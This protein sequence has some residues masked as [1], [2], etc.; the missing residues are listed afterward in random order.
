MPPSPNLNRIAPRFYSTDSYSSITEISR[1]SAFGKVIVTKVTDVGGNV[2]LPKYGQ[3]R[4]SLD[5]IHFWVN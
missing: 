3:Q 4:I 5:N 1:P 2:E